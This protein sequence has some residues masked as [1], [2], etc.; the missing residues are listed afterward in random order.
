[1]AKIPRVETGVIAW[2]QANPEAVNEVIDFVNKMR[3]AKVRLISTASAQTA[4]NALV[5]GD[6]NLIIV[7]PLA[8]SAVQ[9]NVANY[10]GTAGSSYSQSQTQALMTQVAALT[11]AFNALLQQLRN[12]GQNP[13]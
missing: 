11:T 13:G 1:M 5:E 8:F 4:G 9:S 7:V 6:Q 3:A 2:F 12:T 10:S